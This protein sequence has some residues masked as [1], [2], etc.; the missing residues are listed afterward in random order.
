MQ[1]ILWT[2]SVIKLYWQQEFAYKQLDS[3]FLNKKGEDI[4]TEWKH[5][6]P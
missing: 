2:E 4:K 5:S 6:G 3:C 1:F